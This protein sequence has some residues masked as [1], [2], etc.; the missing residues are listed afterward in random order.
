MMVATSSTARARKQHI[1]TGIP[2]MVRGGNMIQATPVP[3][4]L[5]GNL[6]LL[7]HSDLTPP[8]RSSAPLNDNRRDY[9]ARVVVV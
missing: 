2:C 9:L 5:G 7:A 4:G 1:E 6:V 8:G 3:P